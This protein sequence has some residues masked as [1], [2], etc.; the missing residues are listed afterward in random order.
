MSF[1]QCVAALRGLQLLR[2]DQMDYT[3]YVLLYTFI[4]LFMTTQ[5]I[6]Y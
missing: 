1:V 3:E 5:E 6:I 2:N 4:E